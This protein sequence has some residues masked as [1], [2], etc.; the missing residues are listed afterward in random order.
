MAVYSLS[1]IRTPQKRPVPS[2]PTVSVEGTSN[3]VVIKPFLEGHVKT[4]GLYMIPN[5]HEKEVIHKTASIFGIQE[6]NIISTAISTDG[7]GLAT[8][9]DISILAEYCTD[10]ITL[11]FLPIST[12][13]DPKC[14]WRM[15]IPIKVL[16]GTLVVH[17]PTTLGLIPKDKG[18]NTRAIRHAYATEMGIKTYFDTILEYYK[19]EV[20]K[21]VKCN[22]DEIRPQY[23][24]LG[25]WLADTD[26]NT[27]IGPVKPV[28]SNGKGTD[29]RKEKFLKRD[30]PLWM[31]S[32][33]TENEYK[34]RILSCGNDTFYDSLRKKSLGCWCKPEDCHGRFIIQEFNKL[35]I[36]R[37]FNI[38][39]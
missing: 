39:P 38:Q 35:F 20:P 1:M 21:I 28:F 7:T 10:D 29:G 23:Q 27:Y 18:G 19:Q 30:S 36:R 2:T 4:A 6:T 5:V 9:S 8:L 25:E 34:N 17:D 31:T 24:D 15:L 3:K 11:W 14:L 12:E 22:V 32:Q 13:Y 16:A 26:K 33:E 37:F